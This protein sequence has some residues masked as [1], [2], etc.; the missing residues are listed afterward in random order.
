MPYIESERR[1]FLESR[2]YKELLGLVMDMEIGDMNFIISNMVWLRFMKAPSYS[3]GNALVG[4]LESAKLE[5]YRKQLAVY[6]D[7]AIQRNGPLIFQVTN[8]PEEPKRMV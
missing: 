5:F 7:M 1:K 2:T 8:A 4:V 3:T 6:E